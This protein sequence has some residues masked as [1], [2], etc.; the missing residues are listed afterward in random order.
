[1]KLMTGWLVAALFVPAAA[2]A[3]QP[4]EQPRTITVA[5]SATVERDPDRAVVMLAVESQATTAREASQRNAQLMESV[6]A[7]IR[8]EGIADDGIRTVS[9]ELRPEYTRPEQGREPPRIVSYRAINM[10]QVRVDAIQRA[11]V[12]IDAALEA[13]ANRVTG[14]NFELRDP[15]SAR[16]EALREAMAKARREAEA[17]AAAAGQQLGDPLTIHVGQAF[18]P[19]PPPMPMMARA[20]MDVALAPPPPIEGGQLAITATVNAVYRL[21]P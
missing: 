20:E 19:R 10:V 2:G 8:R 18:V 3:Q 5:A 9:Y 4:E 17:I 13:G 14:L 15:E 12:V 16:L 11:G 1:M 7:A 6:L 21:L